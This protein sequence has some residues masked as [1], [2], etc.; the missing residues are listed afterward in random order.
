M[1]VFIYVMSTLLLTLQL[2]RG[3]LRLRILSL[4]L[5]TFTVF[6]FHPNWQS[7]QMTSD[8]LESGLALGF[9]PQTTIT[10]HELYGG[11]VGAKC[12]EAPLV[13]F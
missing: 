2:T 11:P 13:V 5:P 8:P 7:R 3:C 12:F 4:S 9:F 10:P 1:Q 6:P